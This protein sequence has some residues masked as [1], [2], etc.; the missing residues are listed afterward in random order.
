[1]LVYT[2]EGQD[3]AY[4]QWE[5]G[6]F[7]ATMRDSPER[8]LVVLT[9][10]A[11]QQPRF[12]EG[13]RSVVVDDNVIYAFMRQLYTDPPWSIFPG[14]DDQLLRATAKQISDRFHDLIPTAAQK[15]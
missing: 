13:F 4:C 3:W 15:S 10:D 5:C 6:V 2:G 14:V 12:L 8:V 11:K 9:K 1:M 7:E